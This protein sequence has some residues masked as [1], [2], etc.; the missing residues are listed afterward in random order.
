ME[1]DLQ[2]EI[3]AAWAV[4]EATLPDRSELSAYQQARSQELFTAGFLA[5]RNT[6]GVGRRDSGSDVPHHP[7]VGPDFDPQK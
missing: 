3:A 4:Y 2:A 5:A 6:K 7:L 1:R